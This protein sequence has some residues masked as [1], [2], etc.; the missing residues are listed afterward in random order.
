M[1]LPL[2]SGS[3]R[4]LKAMRRTY[5]RERFLDRVALI[6][7]H[8]PDI[9]LTTDIIVGFPGETEA[10]F[11][12]DARGLRGGRLRR[13]VHVHL[14]AAPRDRG[15]RD[16]R[17]LRRRTRSASSAWSAWSRSSSAAPASRPSASSGARSTCSSRAPRAP[18]RRACA[19]A[20]PHGK[21]VHF[22]GLGAPGEIVAGDDRVA[23]ARPRSRARRRCSR[24]P[25]PD[26][27]R[28]RRRR[29]RHRGDASRWRSSARGGARRRA[30]RADVIPGRVGRRASRWRAGDARG[31]GASS[32][33]PRWAP[34]DWVVLAVEGPSDRR[35]G[36]LAGGALPA[37]ARPSRCCRTGSTTSSAWGRWWARRR[38]CRPSTGARSSRPT[39]ATASAGRCACWSPPEGEGLGSRCSATRPRCEVRDDFASAAWKKLCANAVAGILAVTRRRT[40]VAPRARHPRARRG[41]GRGVRGGRPGRGRG[42]ERRPGA[43]DRRR[44]GRHAARLEHVDPRRPRGAG[45]RW[46]GRRATRRSGGS[47]EARHRDARV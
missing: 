15:G 26:G 22:A 16:R 40:E 12:R 4:I 28:R 27:A 31:A 3:S 36:G 17:G 11:A 18:T 37:A 30:L 23:P 46:S 34:V 45:G 29:R 32:I 13:R 19:G 8:N 10:D 24:A 6:R 20:R 21:T 39:A 25:W 1:H 33:P 5:T 42:A 7:E 2:Q 14:L 47:R 38:W 44:A 9:A 41:D 35:R 43:R